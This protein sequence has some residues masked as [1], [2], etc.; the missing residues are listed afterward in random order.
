MKQWEYQVVRINVAPATPS[1]SSDNEDREIP[2]QTPKAENTTP[3]NGSVFS[4]NY[5][6]QE[7]PGYYTKQ[8]PQ[9]EGMQSQ[10]ND[11][12]FQLQLYLNSQGIEGWEAIGLQQA[13]PHTFII[14]KRASNTTNPQNKAAEQDQLK[15]TLDLASK[16]LDMLRRQG[17][18][19]QK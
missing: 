15:I 8:S 14:F 18:N 4:E 7:F 2:S 1:P 12:A 9:H 16:C 6:K 5:L 17:E 13:G 10:S 3:N 19:D 11:P